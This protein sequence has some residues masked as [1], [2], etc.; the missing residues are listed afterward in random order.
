[1]GSN[2][3][4]PKA[5]KYSDP[6]KNFL[7]MLGLVAIIFSL[8][9]CDNAANIKSKP[10]T[11]VQTQESIFTAEASTPTIESQITGNRC[12]Y[13]DLRNI[14]IDFIKSSPQ[15]YKHVSFDD[16]QLVKLE[17]VKKRFIGQIDNKNIIVVRHTPEL[18][19]PQQATLI[20]EETLDQIMPTTAYP[21]EGK[22]GL[23]FV[24]GD[25][26]GPV[27]RAGLYSFIAY[28]DV[29]IAYVPYESPNTLPIPGTNIAIDNDPNERSFRY[30][31]AP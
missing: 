29:K 9:A 10:K 4:E 7:N 1:M 30:P 2:E 17:F 3:F 27:K 6:R 15:G 18:D 24:L 23:F 11:G 5:K 22:N 20:D 13:N 21:V 19:C 12:T 16:A 25:K 31:T 26:K 28:N 14:E 8:S